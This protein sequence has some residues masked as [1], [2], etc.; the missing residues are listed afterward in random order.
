M[1]MT[2]PA[3]AYRRNGV[4]L[5]SMRRDYVASSRCDVVFGTGHPLGR[6]LFVN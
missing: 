3:D 2:Y 5:A 1:V 4:V 6:H